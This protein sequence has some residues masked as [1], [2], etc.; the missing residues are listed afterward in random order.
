MVLFAGLAHCESGGANAT[1][2]FVLASG[3]YDVFIGSSVYTIDA[4]C[5]LYEAGCGNFGGITLLGDTT[6][7]YLFGEDGGGITGINVSSTKATRG[8]GTR[9]FLYA[10]IINCFRRALLLCRNVFLLMSCLTFSVVS[11]A[12][13]LLSLRENLISVVGALSPA[14]RRLFSS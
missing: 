1:K 5:A 10:N 13:R 9:G 8:T 3:G 12:H 14:P 6:K 11:A 7:D 4:A 2:I